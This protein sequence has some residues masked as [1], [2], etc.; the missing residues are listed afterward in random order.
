VKEQKAHQLSDKENKIPK[1]K[2]RKAKYNTNLINEEEIDGST[3]LVNIN[4]AEL[5]V[6][7]YQQAVGALNY[8]ALCTRPDIAHVV[9]Q[10]GKFMVTPAMIHW[11]AVKRVFRYL[12]GT[13]SL[14]L[15]FKSTGNSTPLYQLVS[16][17]D[18]DF[19]NDMEKR[20]S[21]GGHVILL[22]NNLITWKCKK[23]RLTAD[24]TQEAEYIA[25]A[26]C[27]QAIKWISNLFTELNIQ[28]QLPSILYCDNNAAI[29]IT[30]NE[31]QHVKS[32]HID[33]KYHVTRQE[34]FS[35]RI[36]VRR[37]TTEE[38]LAD[39]LTKALPP[40]RFSQLRS[41]LLTK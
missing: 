41:S 4:T 38:N 7:H 12:K 36:E 34:V 1:F 13:A 37:V 9:N 16:Y 19:A 32:K 26:G 8:A 3:L 39:I 30:R 17:A 18:A 2:R 24:S 21:V 10:L 28:L 11:K 6:T 5:N 29:A 22:N 31:G 40:Q 14:K 25:M 20:Q 15:Q 33:I 35:R 23:Q 27:T